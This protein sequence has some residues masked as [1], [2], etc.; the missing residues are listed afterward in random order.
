MFTTG[1]G[2]HTNSP[3]FD[4]YIANSIDLCKIKMAAWYICGNHRISKWTLEDKYCHNMTE[5]CYHCGSICVP[6][7]QARGISVLSGTKSPTLKEKVSNSWVH[8][9]CRMGS[10]SSSVW[11][12]MALGS[13]HAYPYCTALGTPL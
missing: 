6:A 3:Q 12:S 5:S 4:N 10:S 13:I 7:S 2:R 8:Y 1:V 11:N 9:P